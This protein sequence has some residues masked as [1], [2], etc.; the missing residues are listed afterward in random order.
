M[1]KT[2]RIFLIFL[3]SA[4]VFGGI[5]AQASSASYVLDGSQRVAVPALYE[6]D[7]AYQSFAHPGKDDITLNSPQDL[8]I[9]AQ[10]FLFV[11]DTGNNRI[12]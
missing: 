10:G 3:L 6:F 1:K 11:A 8:F 4:T 5:F 2:L 12:V 9:N 7:E